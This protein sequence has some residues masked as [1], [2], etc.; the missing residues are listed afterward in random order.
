MFTTETWEF[1]RL[2]RRLLPMKES[3]HYSKVSYLLCRRVFH[4]TALA[5]TAVC[6][7]SSVVDRR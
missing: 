6:V 3:Q 2:S 5:C 1:Y 4:V 7:Y